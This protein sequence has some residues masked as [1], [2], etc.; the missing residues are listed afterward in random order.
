MISTV[1]YGGQGN[2]QLKHLFQM[3][4]SAKGQQI[5]SQ[6][7]R[8][9]KRSYQLIENVLDKKIG[10]DDIHAAMLA[11][12]LYNEWITNGEEICPGK[13]FSAL[14][15]GIF[16][17]LLTTNSANFR[18]IVNFIRKRA[19]LIEELSCPEE[20]AVDDRK[21]S[22]ILNR[23][24]LGLKHAEKFKLAIIT[25]NSTS[26]VLAVDEQHLRLL[27][28][29]ASSEGHIYK[30]KKLG[31]KAPYHTGFLDKSFDDYV[32]LVN[33]L[34]I[35]QNDLYEYIFHYEDLREELLYQWNQMFNW[36]GIKENI[37]QRGGEILDLSPNKFIS[38]QLLKMKQKKEECMKVAIVTGGTRELE[39]R[40]QRNCTMRNYQ[41]IAVYSSNDL[42]LELQEQLP[43]LEISKC[44]I[45]DSRA[46]KNWSLRFFGCM[47]ELTAL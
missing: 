1:I 28:A 21:F 32:Q 19:R 2:V 23:K 3:L 22:T 30:I 36:K 40:L 16:N 37:L 10:L 8:C 13:V 42:S 44:D 41:V 31:V 45:S 4:K 46:V 15:A 43:G 17:V 33:E 24:S 47:D 7:K 38:K 35:V 39:N 25:L 29:T 34:N 18:D 27:E 5:L 20:L 12:F 26:G 11:N 14:S 6:L 9:D